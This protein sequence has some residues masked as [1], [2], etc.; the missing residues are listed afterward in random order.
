M[1]RFNGCVI[2]LLVMS[3]CLSLSAQKKAGKFRQKYE[4]AEVLVNNGLYDVARTYYVEAYEDARAT[5]QH[6]NI[7]NQIKQKIVLMDCYAMYFHLLDQARELEQMQEMESADK[8]YSDA[9]AYA[10]YEHLN[11]PRIDTMKARSKVIAQTA[12]LS[13]NLTRVDSLNEKGDYVSARELFRQVQNKTEM[14]AND[15]K[16]HGLPA[17]FIQKMD[18]IAQF[19]NKGR[20]AVLQ[21]R[22]IFPDEFKALDSHL[23]QLLNQKAAQTGNSIESDITFVFSLD[24]NGV[25]TQS[26]VGK[27]IIDNDLKDALSEGLRNVQLRQPHRF[28]FTLPVKEELN[29]HISSTPT[30]VWVIKSKKEVKIKDSK[31]KSQ[32]LKEINA[33]LAKAP[34]GKYCFQIHRN[35]IDGHTHTSM[36]IVRAKGGKA[37]KWLKTL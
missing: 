6:K 27:P 11:I 2:F 28:G 18:S 16:N 24:T 9:L 17:N 4:D 14:L 22:Q 35:E 5:R 13:Q 19:P 21:Y 25:L 23:Y 31:R 32:D 26:I 33:K 34:V 36:R 30:E 29:Y 15:W 10:E 12:D 3:L 8:Y 20:N 37:N 1:Q 7:Q